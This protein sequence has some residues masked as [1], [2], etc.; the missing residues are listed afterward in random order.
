MKEIMVPR[1]E[2][3]YCGEMFDSPEMCNFHEKEEHLCPVCKH[4][5]YVYG[6]ERNCALE[7]TGKKCK[8]EKEE[9]GEAKTGA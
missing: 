3:E 6:C 1:W 7:N 8:F 9:A 4:S 2:C 5:Y